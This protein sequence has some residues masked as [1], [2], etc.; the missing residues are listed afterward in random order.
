MKQFFQRIKQSPIL[1]GIGLVLGASLLASTSLQAWGPASRKTFTTA[2]PATYITFNSITDNP[3]HGDERNFVQIKEKNAPNSSYGETVTLKE[4]QKYTVFIY[5]HNNAAANYNL[6]ATNTRAKVLIPKTVKPTDNGGRGARITGFISADNAQPKEV[7][8]E[9]YA[10]AD[11]DM[12]LQYIPNSAII[13]S[14]GAVNGKLL[15]NDVFTNNGALLGYNAIDGKVPGCHQYAGYITLDFQVAKKATPTP[16]KS[17]FKVEKFVSV[18]GKKDWKKNLSVKK[19]DLIDYKI[20][21]TN[22]GETNQ[23][24]VIVKDTLPAGVELV[25]GS[26][27]LANQTTNGKYQKSKDEL[28]TKGLNIGHYLPRGNAFITFTAKVTKDLANC[29][30]NENAVNKVTV[31]TATG[32]K[33]DTATVAIVANCQQEP[34]KIQVCE[35]K[36]KQVVNIKEVD[37]NKKDYS[38]NLDDCKT[39]PTPTPTNPGELPSTGLGLESLASVIGLVS[40]VGSLSYYVNSRKLF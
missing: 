23:S 11:K 22:T 29:A 27:Q 31:T 26:V 6:V 37:F 12:T 39:K 36:T 20:V 17:D 7:W 28:V 34:K 30:G 18:N 19:G 2:K 1:M 9:A 5:F 15:S 40:L 3:A 35:L 38:K 24:D 16:G 25:P 32:Q 33:T 13:H 10:K 21:Y 8:D 4:G 14:K